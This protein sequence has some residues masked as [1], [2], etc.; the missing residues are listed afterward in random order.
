[1]KMT[2]W[3]AQ[4]EVADILLTQTNGMSAQIQ[5]GS[6]FPVNNGH[7]VNSLSSSSKHW[8]A[9]NHGDKMGKLWSVLKAERN[10]DSMTATVKYGGQS[11]ISS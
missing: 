10:Y 5:V 7:N 4:T 2:H 9:N 8:C 11:K 3:T 1:M 6:F